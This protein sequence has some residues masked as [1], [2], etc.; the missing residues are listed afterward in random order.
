MHQ[1]FSEHLQNIVALYD[2]LMQQQPEA[3]P[4]TAPAKPG[5]YLFL[6]EGKPERV[7]RSKS[8]RNRLRNHLRP[9]HNSGAYAFK[10][11]RRRFGT[12]ATYKKGDGRKELQGNPLFFALFLEEIERLKT[13]TIKWIVV[14][15]DVDQYLLELYA[16]M[17]LD[18]PL[19]EFG[20]H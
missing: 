8:L 3:F 7:G 13:L 11:A 20:T 16:A 6:H 12:K 15:N 18:L 10:R 17:E 2:E 5:I 9:D 4:G 14:E 1:K 19:D